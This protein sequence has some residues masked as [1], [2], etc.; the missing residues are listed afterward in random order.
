MSQSSFS[1]AVHFRP[2][3]KLQL[4][5]GSTKL[6]CQLSESEGIY[7]CNQMFKQYISQNRYITN[8]D[9]P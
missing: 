9:C 6:N 5:L 2:Y 4:I 1:R 3:V 7:L 8:M